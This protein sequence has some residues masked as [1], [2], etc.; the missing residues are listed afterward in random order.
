MAF[1]HRLQQNASAV[2]RADGYTNATADVVC[3]FQ[4]DI[5]R[6]GSRANYDAL[7]AA[8]KW[9]RTQTTFTYADLQSVYLAHC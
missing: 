5:E 6:L 7:R 8:L 2:K 3:K 4:S 1:A 9:A